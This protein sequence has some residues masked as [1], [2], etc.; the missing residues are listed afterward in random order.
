MT[1]SVRL[2]RRPALQRRERREEF[3]SELLLEISPERHL[4]ERHAGRGAGRIGGGQVKV[5]EDFIDHGG[6]SEE[7]RAATDTRSARFKAAVSGNIQVGEKAVIADRAH[8]PVGIFRI[9]AEGLAP[10]TAVRAAAGKTAG[11]K[12]GPVVVVC[13]KAVGTFGVIALGIVAALSFAPLS[14]HIS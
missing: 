6:V 5:I 1:G 11:R 12:T 8:E 3:V 7:G 2:V 4:F 10:G 9:G 14:V 13:P